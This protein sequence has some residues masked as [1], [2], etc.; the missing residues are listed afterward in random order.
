MHCFNASSL[1]LNLKD[2]GFYFGIGGVFTFKNAKSL[3]EILPKI[4]KDRLLLET[5]SPYLSPEPF[6]GKKNVPL[7]THLVATKMAE[8]LS[9]DRDDLIRLCTKNSNDLFFKDIA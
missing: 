6:R 3:L 8:L 5:D 2:K 4:P 9:M 7:F 1:L